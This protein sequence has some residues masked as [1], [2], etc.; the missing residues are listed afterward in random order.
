[1]MD[2]QAWWRSIGRTPGWVTPALRVS[3]AVE[4][5]PYTTTGTPDPHS[6][7]RLSGPHGYVSLV[8]PSHALAKL[9]GALTPGQRIKVT[10]EVE[11]APPSGW[12][13]GKRIG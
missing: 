11:D 2:L 10:F 7:V 1:M 4:L 12:P 13:R 8:Q 9:A 5:N 3:E 6:R